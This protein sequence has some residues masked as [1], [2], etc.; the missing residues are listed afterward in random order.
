MPQAP[1]QAGALWFLIGP[2]AFLVVSPGL[3]AHSAIDSCESIKA[4]TNRM[5]TTRLV[6]QCMSAWILA[7]LNILFGDTQVCRYRGD[8]A[9]GGIGIVNFPARVI[10]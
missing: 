10:Q 4:K 9:R 8:I 2:N 1:R 3:A 7:A 5:A 6:N